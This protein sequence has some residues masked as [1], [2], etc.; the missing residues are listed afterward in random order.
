MAKIGSLGNCCL[1]LSILG[2][3]FY[4][5]ITLICIFSPDRLHILKHK[6]KEEDNSLY[7]TAWST[8]ATCAFLY[9][10]IAAGL[11][12]YKF[13]DAEDREK[14]REWLRDKKADEKLGNPYELSEYKKYSRSEIN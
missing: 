5:Y 10:L 12:V 6:K 3:I 9:L 2:F 4:L 7:S 13:N 11:L 14:L 8:S 1:T